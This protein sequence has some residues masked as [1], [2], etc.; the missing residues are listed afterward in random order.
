MSPNAHPH[1]PVQ[2]SSITQ[3]CP[4]LCDPMNCSTPGLPV[5]HQLP[6][7]TQTH[8]HWIGDA[9][10]PSHPLSSPSPPA[11]NLPSITVFSNE[12]VLRIR[13]P[14]SIG[15]SG[16]ASALPM[17]IQDWFPLGWTGWISLLSKGLSHLLQHHSLKASFLRWSA[18][19]RVHYMT[20]GKTIGLTIW[21]FAG[22]L[23]SVFFNMLY[24]FVK[25]FRQG[26]SVF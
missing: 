9:I 2:F 26:E 5:H 6:E 8:V 24:R 13:W 20:N 7:F 3:S 12:S 16:S 23:M 1:P 18:V 14:K 21:T 15:V 17:N 25:A 10:Q 4:I 19:F 11:L 22:K